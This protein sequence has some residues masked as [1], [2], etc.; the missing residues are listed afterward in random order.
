MIEGYTQHRAK[1]PDDFPAGALEN[2]SLALL[3][4]GR[5]ITVEDAKTKCST[6]TFPLGDV[7]TINR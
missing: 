3:P 6:H 1:L 7:A 2:G 5:R 4:N